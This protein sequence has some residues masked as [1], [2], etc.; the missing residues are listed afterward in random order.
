ML[1]RFYYSFQKFKTI[2]NEKRKRQREKDKQ[3][4]NEQIKNNEY[5]APKFTPINKSTNKV[6]IVIDLSFDNLMNERE[7]QK[8]FKQVI[9][10]YSLNRRCTGK[11]NYNF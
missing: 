2:L 7:L 10:C 3:K 6:K 5:Q 11:I 1:I 4:R 9:R 8:T